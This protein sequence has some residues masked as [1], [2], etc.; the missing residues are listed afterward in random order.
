MWSDLALACVNF[1]GLLVVTFVGALDQD[2][3]GKVMENANSRTTITK[4]ESAFAA[5]FG[6]F[7]LWLAAFSAIFA[8]FGE[9]KNAEVF[10]RIKMEVCTLFCF[11]RK[12]QDRITIPFKAISSLLTLSQ[13]KNWAK[14]GVFS[15]YIIGS[16]R[17][18]KA[19]EC[20]MS[21]VELRM[22][23]HGDNFLQ[24][25]TRIKLLSFWE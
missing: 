1:C 23:N 21:N 24:Y 17:L 8:N 13:H 7:F 6:H 22:S 2:G 11:G 5:F 12:S 20:R 14:L 16:A 15:T 25:S 10:A 4:P 19:G 18:I 9:N 3:I